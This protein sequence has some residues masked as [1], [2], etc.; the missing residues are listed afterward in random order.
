M[1]TTAGITDEQAAMLA[2]H[3]IHVQGGFSTPDIERARAE[4]DLARGASIDFDAMQAEVTAALLAKVAALPDEATTDP[5]PAS[6]TNT[7]TPSR[8]DVSAVI[9]HIDL[10]EGLR[11]RIKALQ[12]DLKVHEDAVK[13]ALGEATVGTDA[14]GNVLVRYPHRER[15][16]LDKD[17]VKDLLSP[18]DFGRCS[19]VTPYRTLLYGEG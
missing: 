4:K 10:G 8:V 16:G 14:K 7:A 9:A 18:E 1:T 15:H 17:K 11:D 13:D 19:K 2:A 3:A 6:T 12:A 5:A